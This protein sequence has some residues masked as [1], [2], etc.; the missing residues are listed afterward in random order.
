MVAWLM[1]GDGVCVCVLF[2]RTQRGEATAGGP[3]PQDQR[4]GGQA[5]PERESHR[6]G[7]VGTTFNVLSTLLL[8][9]LI[10]FTVFRYIRNLSVRE[11][12]LQTS[13]AVSRIGAR[14]DT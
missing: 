9:A 11:N 10:C 4:G 8:Y 6:A 14:V 12:S 1:T 5:G 3:N 7:Q 2:R 13:L